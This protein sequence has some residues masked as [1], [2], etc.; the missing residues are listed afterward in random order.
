[1]TT[2]NEAAE[3]IT[4]RIDALYTTTDFAFENEDFTEP[5]P[6][7]AW[8]RFSIRT[9]VRGQ[10]TLGKI[11]SRKYRSVA[12]LM[13]QVFGPTNE[14]RAGNDAIAKAILDIFEGT[15]FSGVDFINGVA[16][17]SGVKRRWTMYIVEIDF[18]YDETK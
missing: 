2:P 12:L 10:N 1:M 7:T 3:A 9:Q 4:A 6:D 8:V 13:A 17:E 14:G 5:P 18:E 11:G 15:S 16:R